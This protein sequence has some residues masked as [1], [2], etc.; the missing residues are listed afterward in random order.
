[1]SV[2]GANSE[3]AFEANVE[4]G[5]L[6]R[7]WSKAQGTFNVELGI[8]TGE[9]YR[10][11]G[12]T[13]AKA[14]DRL[15]G[16]YGD[17]QN[18]A[19]RQFAERVAAEVDARGVLDV[20]RQGV[21]DRGVQIDL[22]YFRP[23]HTLAVDALAEYNANV[24]TVARQLHYS[25]R[26]PRRSL[27][28]ALFVNGLP[29]ATVELKNPNTHQNADHAVAQYRRDRDPNDVF[30][31][32]RALVHFA[33]DPD[34]AFVTTR[35]RGADTQF[36]P[37]NLGSNGPGVPVGAGNPPPP[38]I[39]IVRGHAADGGGYRESEVKPLS[40]VIEELNERFGL[41]LST[42][43]Q[44]LVYQ[45]V[46]GLV[47]D[48]SMQQIALM[49]DEARFGQVADDRLDDIVAENAERNTDFMKLYFDNNEFQKAIKEA[50]RKRAYRI[51]TEPARDEALAKLRSEMRR[52][53]G[54]QAIEQ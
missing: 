35:L 38:V 30:F 13:Q 18:T 47:E 8:D 33:V 7:G 27:D 52:E 6:A 16:F 11:I 54:G 34:R 28:M 53:T 41:D 39:V 21:R 20:L 3:D 12:A 5:L 36:L 14:W 48:I 19:Q 50:A 25:T 9:M 49:N 17:D 23:G 4:A 51:I 37:F 10:F 45:Q 31:A 42:S 15:V 43:D 44:I 29:V 24:L 26:H 22:V 32:K 40:E 46:V 1:M 2:R